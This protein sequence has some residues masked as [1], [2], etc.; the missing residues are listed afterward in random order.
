MGV[1]N[2]CYLY[3]SWFQGWRYVLPHQEDW[4]IC[5]KLAKQTCDAAH[6]W[7]LMKQ[8]GCLTWALN[9]RSGQLL[10]KQDQT[11]RHSCGVLHGPRKC[12]G[13]QLISCGTVLTSQLAQWGSLLTTKS[14]RLWMFVMKLKKTTSK[15]KVCLCIGSSN[16]L[17]IKVF[18][19][20]EVCS[21]VSQ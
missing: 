10:N 14:Y 5:W 2:L 1:F 15:L 17:Q 9:H 7:Y 12:K 19:G 21:F 13:W 18:S 4:L 3:Y 8:T 11:D 20:D 16:Y 6:F